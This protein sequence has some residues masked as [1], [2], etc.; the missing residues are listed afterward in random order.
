MDN[1]QQL[2]EQSVKMQQALQQEEVVSDING[3]RIV[4]RGDQY[5]REVSINGQPYP[6]VAEA[7]NDAIQKTQSLAAQKIISLNKNS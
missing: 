2:Q 7:M 4:M 3:V 6:Q 1:L 5:V